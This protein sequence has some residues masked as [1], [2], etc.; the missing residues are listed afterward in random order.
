V[1]IL[2]VDGYIAIAFLQRMS[3]EIRAACPAQEVVGMANFSGQAVQ[4]R[5]A[6][7][8]KR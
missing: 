3:N 4:Q 5:R 1:Q 8:V 6:S 7:G 2:C